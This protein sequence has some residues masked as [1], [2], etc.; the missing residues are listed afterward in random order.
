M[1]SVI[2]L[3]D[4]PPNTSAYMVAGYVVFFVIFGIYLLSFIIRRRNLEKDL[5]TLETIESESVVVP[6]TA[7][8]K[9]PT[10]R[11]TKTRTKPQARKRTA[12]RK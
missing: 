11:R 8:I 3:Q 10:N 1:N 9:A 7:R 12:R 5:Q 2:W 4:A 6:P